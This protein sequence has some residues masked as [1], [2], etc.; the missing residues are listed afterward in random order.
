MIGT[1]I[2]ADKVEYTLVHGLCTPILPSA[3]SSLFPISFHIF[4]KRGKGKE[5][6]RTFRSSRRHRKGHSTQETLAFYISQ[7]H[8][9]R[10]IWEWHFFVAG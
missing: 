3:S 10:G 4:F 1:T 6:R 8:G 5:G 7:A 2:L 9:I